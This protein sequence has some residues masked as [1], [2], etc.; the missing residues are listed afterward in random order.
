MDIQTTFLDSHTTRRRHKFPLLVPPLPLCLHQYY[1]NRVFNI[2][3]YPRGW[4]NTLPPC[5]CLS[6]APAAL[7]TGNTIA[8]HHQMR[9][10]TF[11]VHYNNNSIMTPSTSHGCHSHS[12]LFVINVGNSCLRCAFLRI[13]RPPRFICVLLVGIRWIYRLWVVTHRSEYSERRRVHWK[14]PAKENRDT[15]RELRNGDTSGGVWSVDPT[16]TMSWSTARSARPR[17]LTSTSSAWWVN[18]DF[19]LDVRKNNPF[20][21][22]I[23]QHFRAEGSR[24]GGRLRVSH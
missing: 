10:K 22:A 11:P 8:L 16:R 23:V 20:P 17:S 2:A 15:T 12:R 13:K 3:T 4:L 1:Y 14:C 24:L 21:S 9:F 7:L 19:D 6:N 5:P 18:I